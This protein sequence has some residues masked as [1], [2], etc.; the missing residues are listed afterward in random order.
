MG[1][2]VG[3]TEQQVCER[4]AKYS[5]DY[6]YVRGFTD[7]NGTI[8]VRCKHCGFEVEKTMWTV[9]HHTNV[10]CS[11]CSKR[12]TKEREEEK[13]KKHR[14]LL[15]YE[16]RMKKGNRHAQLYMK[17]CKECGSLF[18]PANGNNKVYC[19]LECSN[20]AANR[21]KEMR[22]RA[23]IS[24]ALVDKDIGLK[25]LYDRDGG[26]CWLCG[27]MC[28][29][30]DYS[31]VDGI[32]VAGNNYPSIDHV[33]ALANGG[34]HSWGNVKLAHRICNSLKSDHKY[35]DTPVKNFFQKNF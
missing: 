35:F 20:R 21:N 25:R 7:T 2:F 33:I 19:G 29:P 1:Q 12:E 16:K 27:G 10:R 14:E 23:K 9:R 5:Q 3:L 13:K 28:D 18:F 4:V 6:E 17:T 11:E 34:Q 32:F 31:F 26:R 15:D 22:R 8:I 30:N 24:D